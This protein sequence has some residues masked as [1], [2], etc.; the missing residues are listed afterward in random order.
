MIVARTFAA[1]DVAVTSSAGD[2]LH[3]FLRHRHL[4]FGV[5]A[6][7]H[8]N[9]VAYAL[10]KQCA[11]AYSAFY[12]AILAIAGLGNAQV[13]REV[14]ILGIHRL[15]QAAHGFHHNH[16]VRGFYRYHHVEEVLR[17]HHAEKF[18]HALHH[19]GWSVAITAHDAVAERTMVHAET[20]C[21]AVFAANGYEW[22]QCFGDFLYLAG[23]F[24]VAES[25][26]LECSR[27]VNKVAR[28]DAHLVGL[29]R[30]LECC[31][32]IEVDISHQWHIVALID[33]MLAYHAYVVGL[34]HTLSSESHKVGSGIGYAA[35]LRHTALYVVGA[36]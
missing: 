12:A 23:I 19:S 13:Q 27:H 16:C 22:H 33:K 29:L 4:E 32:G 1:V 9:G 28:I 15:H 11:N 5:F 17:H 34:A 31:L 14:H 20:H 30:C 8:A 18:H 26:F 7:R 36:G 6:E 24:F 21:S 3:Q 25:E 10:G 2:I 35:A